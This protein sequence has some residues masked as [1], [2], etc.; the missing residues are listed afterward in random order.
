MNNKNYF[1][2]LGSIL[3][4]VK[5]ELHLEK[6]MQ[7]KEL[8]DNWGKVV[9]NKFQNSSKVAYI[10]NKFSADI[11]VVAVSSAVVAQELSFFKQDIIN[12][13]KRVAKDFQYNIKDIY[14]DANLWQEIKDESKSP[15][16][17]E[18][19]KYYILQKRFSKEELDRIELPQSLID[20]VQSS[21]DKEYFYS[22]ELKQNLFE[23][24]IRDLKKQHWMKNNGFPAC[25]QCGI[26]I[27]HFSSEKE[28]LC[29]VCKYKRD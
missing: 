2:N 17:E 23:T 21:L 15:S 16:N 18:H 1:N 24:I 8:A 27:S 3:D 22:E 11:L 5:T 20:S 28:N 13:I 29:P 12:K 4:S 7:Q 10:Y 9:G 14:F 25:N 26:P 6:A 19:E